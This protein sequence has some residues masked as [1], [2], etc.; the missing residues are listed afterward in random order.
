MVER[1]GRIGFREVQIAR[2]YG[3]GYFRKIPSVRAIDDMVSRVAMRKGNHAY[4]SYAYT[5]VRR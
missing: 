2:F 1:I 4:T 3:H 5:M